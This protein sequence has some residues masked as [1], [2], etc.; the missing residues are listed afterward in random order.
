MNKTDYAEYLR[1]PHWKD[2]VARVR[3]RS[4]GACERCRLGLEQQATHH[5]TYVHKGAEVVTQH[6]GDP[7]NEVL[8]VCSDCHD[9]L[10]GKSKLDPVAFGSDW[11]RY[12]QATL[13]SL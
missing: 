8:G 1:S 11:I 13:K 5:L 6:V 7:A 3:K 10:H 2:V 12:F 9:F 4:G